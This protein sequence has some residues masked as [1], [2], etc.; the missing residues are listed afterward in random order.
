MPYVAESLVVENDG[1]LIALIHPDYD[2]ASLQGVSSSSKLEPI[3]QDNIEKLNHELPGTAR[4]LPIRFIRKNLKNAQ[5]L[6]KEVSISAL[7]ILPPKKQS[8]RHAN[9]CG[10]S[11]II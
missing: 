6:Y 8:H 5:A 3:M 2:A 7:K 4:L 9:V 1:K 10:F 11:C